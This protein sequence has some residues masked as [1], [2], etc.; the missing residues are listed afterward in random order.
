MKRLLLSLFL[1]A[2]CAV[3]YAQQV[4]NMSFDDWSRKGVTWYPYAKGTPESRRVWDSAN[5]GLKPLRANVAFPEYEH[6]AV[7]GHGKAAAKVVSR[8][9]LWAFVTGNLYIGRFVKVVNFSGAEMYYGTPFHA[10]PKSMSGYVHYIPGKIDYAK[11]PYQSM[12]GRS[13]EALIEVALYGWKEPRHF[14]SNDGPSHRGKEDPQLVGIATLV[15]SKDTGG[16]IPFEI[17]ID[18]CSDAA[19]TYLFIAALSSR[20]GEFFTGSSDSVLYVDEFKFN[21]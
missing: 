3:S 11:K 13:D 19:P 21:Y 17:T 18:Y 8:K 16:Y 9:V 5:P 1:L 15:L 10:R 2:A 12:K 7:P 14:V 4:Y 6:V 20:F